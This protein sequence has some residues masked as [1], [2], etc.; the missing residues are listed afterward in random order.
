MRG[1]R[2]DRSGAGAGAAAHAGG[3]EHHV[4]AGEMIADLVDHLLGR[5]APD[6]GLRAGAE[7]FGDLDAHLDDALG[8]RHGE[9]L[10]VGVGDDEVAAQQA[11]RDHVVDGVAAGAAD[12]EHG[13]PRLELPDVGH[14][15]IDGHGL[16]LVR[17]RTR[18]CRRMCWPVASGRDD[19]ALG[20]QK[21]SRSHR[22]TREK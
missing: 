5:G 22:P 4:R 15:E 14:F 1:L 12:A 10:R 11:G 13:D 3:D 2:D 18:G 7:T 16:P 17:A 20:H 8:L 9:R 21:L 19:G 6:V